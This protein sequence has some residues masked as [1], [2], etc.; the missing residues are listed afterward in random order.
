MPDIA[1]V[2]SAY[3]TERPPLPLLTCFIL[4]ELVLACTIALRPPG[5]IRFV[6]ALYLLYT[7]FYVAPTY[8]AGRPPDNYGWGCAVCG[9]IVLNAMLL[10]I[11]PLKDIR[12]L[13]DPAPLTDKPLY[14]RIGYA[15]CIL[16]NPRLIGTNAQV[17]LV[18]IAILRGLPAELHR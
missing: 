4:P 12:Y 2:E 6:A 8:T 3:A 7:A 10:V 17:C 1:A 16:H 14:K 9:G 13:K 5:A 18:S 11:D 15:F